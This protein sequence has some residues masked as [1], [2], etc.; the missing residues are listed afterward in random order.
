M[1]LVRVRVQDFKAIEDIDISLADASLLVGENNSGKSSVLQAVHFASRLMNVAPEANKQSTVSL[2]EIEYIPTESY[3]QIGF[4][5]D[6]GNQASQPE[7]RFG[8]SEQVLPV[9]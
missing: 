2:R 4:N 7:K 8:F 3:K 1:K 9:L 5:K 6:W